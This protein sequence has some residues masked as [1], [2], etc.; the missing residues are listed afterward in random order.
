MN[1][2]RRLI[3]KVP[4]RECPWRKVS[5]QGYL[6]GHSA[7]WYAD[8]VADNQVPSCHLRDHG[9]GTPDTAFCVGAL[10][11]AR[12]GCIMPKEPE[13]VIAIARQIEPNPDCFAR[14]EEFYAYHTH[15][16]QYVRPLMRRLTGAQSTQGETV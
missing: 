12:N 8:V 9:P 2:V 3:H 14:P 4:C 11:T 7:E 1:D 15:G 10:H 5:A 16:G 6:G 13:Q